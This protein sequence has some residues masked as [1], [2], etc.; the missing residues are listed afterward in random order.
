M[1]ICETFVIHS[2]EIVSDG[3]ASVL[4]SHDGGQAFVAKE[5]KAFGALNFGYAMGK[6]SWCACLARGTLALPV[7]PCRAKPSGRGAAVGSS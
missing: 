5:T 6:A 2:H 3:R 7:T 4:G 1:D